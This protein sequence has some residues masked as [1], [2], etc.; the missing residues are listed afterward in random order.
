MSEAYVECLV[1]GR[2]NT[3]AKVLKILLIV[4]AVLTVAA[5]IL[6]AK[7]WMFFIAVLFGI[8]AYIISQYTDVE[9]EYLYIDKELVIDKIY[10]QA[11]RKRVA[12]YSFDKV[13]V[14]AP[15]KSY[16]LD[17]FGKLSDKPKDYSIG[18]EEQPDLR[19]VMFYEGKEQIIFSPNE[20]LVKIMK[21]AA[22]R[23]V[24]SD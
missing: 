14:I 4:L 9:Y 8:G 11:K 5:M 24:F 2:P 21:N 10:N 17:N 3:L 12:T 19:Y 1:K 15:I 23:K 20:E 18:Y 22:P 13:I 7:F 6:L 16:H